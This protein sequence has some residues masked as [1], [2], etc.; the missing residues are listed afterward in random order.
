MKAIVSSIVILLLIFNVVYSNSAKAIDVSILWNVST[1]YSYDPT[2]NIIT[3]DDYRRNSLKYLYS[4]GKILEKYPQFRSNVFL[5]PDIYKYYEKYSAGNA[6]DVSYRTSMKL[7]ESIKPEELE[8]F[9]SHALKQLKKINV[10]NAYFSQLMFECASAVKDKKVSDLTTQKVRD[11][12][13]L[14]HLSWISD[15]LIEQKPAVKDLLIKGKNFTEQEKI[16]LLRLET[17]FLKWSVL[18]F[19]KIWDRDIIDL[20]ST[21]SEE[22]LQYDDINSIER[23]I[24]EL[25]ES[26]IIK[27]HNSIFEDFFKRKPNI[28]KLS[29][30]PKISFFNSVQK[31]YA[32]KMFICPDSRFLPQYSVTSIESSDIKIK[33]INIDAADIIRSSENERVFLDELFKRLHKV[34]YNSTEKLSVIVSIEVFS[35]LEKFKDLTVVEK[36]I[37]TFSTDPLLKANKIS[38]LNNIET[39]Q[40]EFVENKLAEEKLKLLNKLSSR[41]M[42]TLKDPKNKNIIT[43]IVSNIFYSRDNTIIEKLLKMLDSKKE[44]TEPVTKTAVQNKNIEFSPVI[45]GKITKED[46]WD[47][48]NSVDLDHPYVR[49]FHYAANNAYVYFMVVPKTDLIELIGQ[50]YIFS[51]VFLGKED[52]SE[53]FPE[54][55][56]RLAFKDSTSVLYYWEN[57]KW[58]AYKGLSDVLIDNVL[59]LKIPLEYLR[60]RPEDM[61]CFFSMDEN[62]KNVLTT[63]DNVQKIQLSHYDKIQ[64]MK[65][66]IKLISPIKGITRNEDVK[67]SVEYSCFDKT[68]AINK[69]SLVIKLDG[70][71]LDDIEFGDNSA[72]A[73]VKEKLPEG[74]H[75]IETSVMDTAGRLSN[76]IRSDFFVDRTMPEIVYVP[77][78]KLENTDFLRFEAEFSDNIKISNSFIFI[79]PFNSSD[80]YDKF[81]MKPIHNNKYVGLVPASQL[82]LSEK[83][84]YYFIVSDG[85]NIVTSPQNIKIPYTVAVGNDKTAPVIKNVQY[86]SSKY[87][88]NAYINEVSTILIDLVSNDS[89]VENCIR[90]ENAVDF[91]SYSF[92]ERYIPF[93]KNNNGNIKITATDRS[94]NSSFKIVSSLQ[95]L[96]EMKTPV[97]FL[98]SFSQPY[99][100][101]SDLASDASY[102]GLTMSFRSNPE[103]PVNF[104]LSGSLIDSANYFRS[105]FLTMIKE[106]TVADN[107]ELLGSSYTPNILLSLDSNNLELQCEQGMRNIASVS[108]KIPKVFMVP[109]SAYSSIMIPQLKELGYENLILEDKMFSN[110]SNS[111]V[112]FMSYCGYDMNALEINTALSEKFIEAVVKNDH[113]LFLKP[114]FEQMEKNPQKAICLNIVGETLGLKQWQ[115]GENPVDIFKSLDK[116][117]SSLKTINKA[118]FMKASSFF[119]QAVPDDNASEI[120]YYIPKYLNKHSLSWNDFNDFSENLQY[121]KNIFS[122]I[123][124]EASKLSNRYEE[125]KETIKRNLV[126][127][128]Y[129]FGLFEPKKDLEDF[130]KVTS[131]YVLLYAQKYMEKRQKQYCLEEDVNKDGIKEVVIGNRN[132]LWI[133]SRYGGKLLYWFDLNKRSIIVGNEFPV[134]VSQEYSINRS[135]EPI[136]WKM[137]NTLSLNGDESRKYRL[138][139]RMFSDHITV[140]G[141][142]ALNMK[143]SEYEVVTEENSVTFTLKAETGI[144]EKKFTLKPNYLDVE[145]L[146]RNT[147]S[148]SIDVGIV[149]ENEICP[150]PLMVMDQPHTTL[151]FLDNGVMNKRT[152]DK[153]VFKTYSKPEKTL[154]NNNFGGLEYNLKYY[155]SPLKTNK[156]FK[157]IFSV[158]K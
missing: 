94:G 99:S 143:N 119:D 138:R 38:S 44:R 1:D 140:N 72:Y 120:S 85:R 157:I 57:N 71:A 116:M 5:G 18:I 64:T 109:F 34:Y 2:E 106:E 22:N 153:V 111:G 56:V 97:V 82:D 37:Q 20:V 154:K 83:Y 103:I 29:S 17:I 136:V 113:T 74:R 31:K 52:N 128:Q 102:N 130:A 48:A 122:D 88:I 141:I 135:V 41:S 147:S 98:V 152:K 12:I 92:A 51:F 61:Y 39:F 69:K 101:L 148:K 93:L 144:L 65:P 86:I 70:K 108:Q 129:N 100:V 14:Y 125:L 137:K 76:I 146:F 132:D 80:V 27:T 156:S 53:Y 19:K 13:V 32:P 121:F 81:E 25:N 123:Y 127:H 110:N 26:S 33:T 75:I 134:I 151:E 112:H 105:K 155:F 10:N 139:T 87:Q 58:N 8:E 15:A 30:T 78:Q 40:P 49:S 4:F 158:L 133:F 42:K 79:R 45:D 142:A 36:I 55:F 126:V 63:K 149:I 96:D 84:E 91:V 107:W 115:Q 11:F 35:L 3:K 47:K 90:I 23:E 118:K 7:T 16:Y 104:Y 145:Y 54:F 89:V 6:F 50:D 46:L 21:L 117:L 68:A 28:F 62:G 24:L 43:A 131:S 9:I 150:S 95:T 60:T 73:V 59:E 66:E 124:N 67:I 114:F 77:V